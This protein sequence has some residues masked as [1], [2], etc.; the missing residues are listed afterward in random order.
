MDSNRKIKRVYRMPQA[1]ADIVSFG[2]DFIDKF[3]FD[4]N[5][6]ASEMPMNALR[7]IVNIASALRSEQFQPKFAPTQ[8]RLFE[9]EFETENNTFASMKLKNSSIM[10]NRNVDDL[11]KAFEFLT[12]FKL[13]WYESLNKEGKKVTT[14]GGL[15]TAPTYSESG[16]T[17]FLISSYWLKYLV[18]I[19]FF[20]KTLYSLFYNFS[21]NK[22]IIFCLWLDRLPE[23]GTIIKLETINEKFGLNYSCAKD[24]C[25]WFL[26]PIKTK[27]DTFNVNSFNYSIAKDKISIKKYISKQIYENKFPVKPATVEESKR[28]YKI[29]YFKDRHLL[30]KEQCAIF[31]LIYKNRLKDVE[32]I[33]NGYKL[34]LSNCRTQKKKA[35]DFTGK[36][37]LDTLQE[38]IRLEYLKTTAGT[39]NKNAYPRIC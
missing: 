34:F 27:L 24:L 21:N 14:Y 19:P 2:H 36:N 35:T 5:G 15:I 13:G 9:E 30:T 6:K 16:Y 31:N 10:V 23:D 32:N 26:K 28:N 18:N 38:C 22:Q 20:N 4:E 3:F 7:I 33:T 8:L 29:K 12:Q 1:N 11:Q 17:T 25:R 39:L 37:F